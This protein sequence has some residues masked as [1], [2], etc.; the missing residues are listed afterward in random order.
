MGF[1]IKGYYG[2]ISDIQAKTTEINVKQAE[3]M[4]VEQEIRLIAEQND[5]QW[6]DYLL[7]LANCESKF[8]QYAIGDAGKSRGIFQ[9]HSGYHPEVSSQ[10]AF[11]VKC[12]TEWTMWRINSG[13][14]KEWTC[15][16]YIK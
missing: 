10:C 14:Q 16:R 13:H 1:A 15:D 6:T 8:K 9:I 3:K 12:A 4:S 11:N 7:R 2:L 5:F